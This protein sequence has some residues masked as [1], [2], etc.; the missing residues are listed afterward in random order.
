MCRGHI[1]GGLRLPSRQVRAGLSPRGFPPGSTRPPAGV[2]SHVKVSRTVLAVLLLVL[3]CGR[4]AL[5]FGDLGP[6]ASVL[7][8]PVDPDDPD[9]P[10]LPDPDPIVPCVPADE[11]CDGI[12]NDCDAQ[13]DEG[14]PAEPCPNGGAS[15][16]VGGRR[17]E[18]PRG[19]AVCQP[20]SERVCFVS[21]CT[22][23]G[24]QQ[25]E[26]D[27][28]GWRR[29]RE[30]EPPDACKS[31]DNGFGGASDSEEAERCCI[32]EGFCC[33]DYWDLDGDGDTDEMV[34][35]CDGVS[36]G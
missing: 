22:I 32:E 20:G 31:D 16:C 33:E 10:D 29:C 3:G 18:C 9:D 27:G 15:Y 19:C 13:I 11:R 23:W 26:S 7:E 30:Q 1:L 25:C 4:S 5:D 6:D 36:C 21:Y 2:Q 8:D 12:D 17:T 35:A 14:L 24:E 28:R 34:G